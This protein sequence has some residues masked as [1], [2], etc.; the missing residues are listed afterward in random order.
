MIEKLAHAR[1]MFGRIGKTL[2]G[3]IDG[4]V[5]NASMSRKRAMSG[6]AE[7]SDF[8]D[9]HAVVRDS[10]A[11]VVLKRGRARPLWFGHPWVYSNAVDRVEG[12]AEPGSIVSLVDH[13]GRF[14]GRGTYNARSQIQV[15]LVTRSEEPI[16]AP[17]FVRRLRSAQALRAAVGL[18]SA[19]TD[20]YRLVN[21]EGDALPGLVVDV[22]GDAAAYQVSTLGM[23]LWREEIAQAIEET[24]HSKTIYEVAAGSF[25]DVEGFSAETRVVRGES[26]A[27]VP[28][29]EDGI[30]LEAE[31]L[32]GQKTGLFLDQR[33][34]RRRVG[35]MVAA[36]PAKF[37]R[38]LD[39]Y[40]Y[41]GGF[42]L[43][44]GRAGATEITAV[45][46][47][48]RAIGR[49]E[50]HAAANGVK[51]RAVE[52]DTFRFLETATPRSYDLVIVDP[53]KFA[54]AR[55]DLEAAIKGYERLS[56]LALTACAPG[57]I[58]VSCSCSQNVGMEDFERI[59]AAGARQAAREVRIIDRLGPG[60][61]HPVPP[62][63]A[64]GQYLKVLV[65]FVA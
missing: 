11:K 41:A 53:P 58:L 19:Q 51:I 16:D 40:S 31:P 34:S 33:P 26:R 44:A 15:R 30:R 45:D 18:P 8:V 3:D 12:A 65:A 62:G 56:A 64:E 2:A 55:K 50:A 38:V 54:K 20:A 37:A 46:S 49:I 36:A 39:C 63:F 6:S 47:S 4:E 10:A 59:L 27:Q 60:E 5:Y 7:T 57:A 1:R 17:F 48:S 61:D 42:A 43:Q 29:H 14:I 35:Q 23:A 32:A 21:S 52:S 13:D 22:F 28:C 9:P 25:A 24:L